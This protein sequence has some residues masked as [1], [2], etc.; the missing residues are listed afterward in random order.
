MFQLSNKPF[1]T[2]RNSS[3]QLPT[4][5]FA[6]L[7]I[8]MTLFFSTPFTSELGSSKYYIP[9]QTES[10]SILPTSRSTLSTFFRK[11]HFH[12]QTSTHSFPREKKVK[13]RT[14]EITNAQI[15]F[16]LSRYGSRERVPS[17]G[18]LQ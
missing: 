3:N 4:Q 14:N 15:A 6:K 7:S 12:E 17:K 11:T 18:I 8:F 10:C 9:I 1:F 13:R 2:K 16:V 5:S